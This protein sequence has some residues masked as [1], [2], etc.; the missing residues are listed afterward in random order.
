MAKT[1]LKKAE[2]LLSQCSI[3]EGGCGAVKFHAN[4]RDYWQHSIVDLP[5]LKNEQCFNCRNKKEV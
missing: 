5:N 4:K 2:L 1:T 3:Q